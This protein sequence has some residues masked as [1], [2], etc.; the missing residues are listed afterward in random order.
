MTHRTF[1]GLGY[2]ALANELDVW[3]RLPWEELVARV[4][5]PAT[6]LTVVVE[7]EEI[8]LELEASW[9]NGSRTAVRIQGV[10]RGLSHWQA[11]RIDESLT[12]E[13]GA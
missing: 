10:A 12:I 4:D 2:A 1:R 8:R 5:L 3:R 7:D 9:A 11:E 6:A 13:M